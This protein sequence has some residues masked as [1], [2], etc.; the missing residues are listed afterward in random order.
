MAL[1]SVVSESAAAAAATENLLETQIPSFHPNIL[2]QKLYAWDP[3]IS[4]S[5]AIQVIVIHA[6][7]LSHCLFVCFESSLEDMPI[8]FRE[9]EG[10]GGRRREKDRE[11]QR[12]R[13]TDTDV[14]GK[15]QSVASRM[16]LQPFGVQDGTPT[17]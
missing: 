13:E 1:E 6:E 16:C 7:S 15:H 17:S 8:D 12:D 3:A 10:G 14:R 5:K 11:R 4:S 9:R 2:N